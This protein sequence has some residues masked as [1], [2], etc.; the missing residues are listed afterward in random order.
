MKINEINGKKENI[1]IIL[2]IAP[3]LTGKCF[4]KTDLTCKTL[5]RSDVLKKKRG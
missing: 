2:V 5:F 4:S 3:K 1:L